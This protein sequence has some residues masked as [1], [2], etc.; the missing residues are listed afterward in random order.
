MDATDTERYSNARPKN[1]S[2]LYI[3]A[4]ALTPNEGP[5]HGLHDPETVEWA[6][7]LYEQ[8][9]RLVVARALALKRDD[10]ATV[11][12]LESERAALRD[13]LKAGNAMLNA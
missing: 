3:P 8:I 6:H 12:R 13:E 1:R 10:M 9:D 5:R 4:S 2:A 11:A 7:R